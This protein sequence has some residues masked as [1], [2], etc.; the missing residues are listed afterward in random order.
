MRW[1]SELKPAR[2]RAGLDSTPDVMI[3]LSS[4]DDGPQ[5]NETTLR[6]KE[7]NTVRIGVHWPD[8]MK[9]TTLKKDEVLAILDGQNL[10]SEGRVFLRWDV[11]PRHL[12]LLQ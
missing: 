8:D 12:C 10:V 11:L 4:P 3:N 9:F 7:Y 1:K 2:N 6:T 5:T